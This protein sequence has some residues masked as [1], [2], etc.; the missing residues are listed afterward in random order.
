MG[1]L[2]E[3]EITLYKFIKVNEKVTIKK[4]QEELD[5]KLVG[6][7]GRL[8]KDEIVEKVK[9]RE[10]VGYEAKNYVYYKIKEETKDI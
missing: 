10:G 4:I 9:V 5:D 2:S 8:M 1:I 7:L 3:S 6:G